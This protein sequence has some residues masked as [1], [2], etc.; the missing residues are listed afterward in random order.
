MFSGFFISCHIFI[1][2]T[3]ISACFFAKFLRKQNRVAKESNEINSNSQI[4]S[5]SSTT[6]STTSRQWNEGQTSG[7]MLSTPN[8][9]GSIPDCSYFVSGEPPPAYDDIFHDQSDTQLNFQHQEFVSPIETEEVLDES[10]QNV[11]SQRYVQDF[12]V[13]RQG[14]HS[15]YKVHENQS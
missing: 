4:C 10:I 5:E 12:L 1:I 7:Q 6:I 3:I 11:N 13:Q 15:E 2:G 14:L 9:Q 8:H